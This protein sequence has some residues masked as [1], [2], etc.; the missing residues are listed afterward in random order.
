MSS[1][2]QIDAL[3]TAASPPPSPLVYGSPRGRN[4][5]SRALVLGAG[6][7]LGRSIMAPAA[8]P[9]ARGHLAPAG[10]APALRR[11]YRYAL[12]LGLR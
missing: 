12:L 10:R 4:G 7:E 1:P 11:I 6:R 2:P 9:P 3:A 8:A 5:W